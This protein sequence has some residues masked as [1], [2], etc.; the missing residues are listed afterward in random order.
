M[1]DFHKIL[2]NI[3]C[4]YVYIRIANISFDW[5]GVFGFCN[6]KTD[7]DCALSHMHETGVGQL[8]DLLVVPI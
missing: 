2:I 7:K 3:F 6:N 8:P 1:G 4:K 5:L